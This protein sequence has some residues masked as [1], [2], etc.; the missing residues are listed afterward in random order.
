ML[1]LLVYVTR[2]LTPC[3]SKYD[4]K[5]Y[6]SLLL[7]VISIGGDTGVVLAS[8]SLHAGIYGDCAGRSAVA[9]A[10][11]YTEADVITGR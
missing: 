2:C 7:L 1:P 6:R 9:D 3:D 11:I 4:V 5:N 8:T 10:A